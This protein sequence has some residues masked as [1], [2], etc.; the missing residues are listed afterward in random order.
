M[1]IAVFWLCNQVLQE[2]D[3]DVDAAIEYLIAENE[4]NENDCSDDQLSSVKE[5]DSDG[6][7][8]FTVD[9]FFVCIKRSTLMKICSSMYC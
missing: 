7:V 3:G 5:K 2:V 6:K 1:I 8:S 9:R 4:M